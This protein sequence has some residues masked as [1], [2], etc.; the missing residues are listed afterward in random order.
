MAAAAPFAAIEAQAT[1]DAMAH[2]ANVV[3]R[4]G[5]REVPGRFGNP[6]AEAFGGAVGGSQPSLV[7][8]NA[9]LPADLARGAELFIGASRYR[10]D[11]LHPDG[12]GQTLILLKAAP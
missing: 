6:Y 9:G 11:E 7:C 3:A 4:V 8:L 2:L 5:G 1:I 12:H 10:I